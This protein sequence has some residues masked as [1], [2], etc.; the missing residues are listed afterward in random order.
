MFN[1]VP[2][3]DSFHCGGSWQQQLLQSPP[4]PVRWNC[5]LH[6]INLIE[7]CKL[8]SLTKSGVLLYLFLVSD[9]SWQFL[10]DTA[11]TKLQCYLFSTFQGRLVREEW[12]TLKYTLKTA[13]LQENRH[14]VLCWIIF[15]STSPSALPCHS[16]ILHL[17]SCVLT[18]KYLNLL[19]VEKEPA[20]RS[21]AE[22]DSTLLPVLSFVWPADR[23]GP[24]LVEAVR[25]SGPPGSPQGIF[26]AGWAHYTAA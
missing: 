16:T 17:K 14:F 3:P 12:Q 25:G 5:C 9:C 19:M 8:W 22:P 20:E 2:L 13:R 4:S 26:E 6:E 21:K 23:R 18:S 7:T 11:C 24:P 10:Q 15:M 1:D